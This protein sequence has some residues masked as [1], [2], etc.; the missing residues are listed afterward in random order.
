[1]LAPSWPTRLTGAAAVT[2]ITSADERSTMSRLR[3]SVA[4]RVTAVCRVQSGCAA[5]PDSTSS[6]QLAS[7][8]TNSVSAELAQRPS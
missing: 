2:E 8:A 7:L 5:V 3:V 4:A 1:M 6:A